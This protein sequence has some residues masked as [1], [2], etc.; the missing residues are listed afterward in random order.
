MSIPPEIFHNTIHKQQ[1]TGQSPR[2]GAALIKD[3]RT[4]F[5]P[6]TDSEHAEKGSVECP[7]NTESIPI[8]VTPPI[9]PSAFFQDGSPL[10]QQQTWRIPVVLPLAD[11]TENTLAWASSLKLLRTLVHH[12]GIYALAACLSPLLSLLLTPFLV[13]S[14]SRTDYGALVVLNAASVFLTALTQAG[15]GPAFAHTVSSH[16]HNSPQAQ[17]TALATMTRLLLLTSCTITVLLWLCA[18]LV[19]AVLLRDPV[20]TSQVRVTAIIVCLQN[21]TVPGMT[22]LRVSGRARTFAL[23][24]TGSVLCNLVVTL[25]LVKFAHLGLMGALYGTASST[26]VLIAGSAPFLRNKH[27]TRFHREIAAK[28]LAF[29]VTT[30]PGLLSVWVL[31]LADR[32]FLLCYGSLTQ[33]ASYS[34]AYTLSSMLAP[35]VIS[36]FALAWYALMHSLARKPRAKELF[37][38]IFRWYST[39]LLFA[40]CAGAVVADALLRG[41]FPPAYAEQEMIIPLIALA[42][43]L[44]G[45]FDLFAVGLH[46]RNKVGY[47]VFYMPC[48]A[49]LNLLC[50]IVLIPRYGTMGAALATLLAYLALAIMA[51]VV[52]QRVYPIPFEIGR[53]TLA[54]ALGVICYTVAFWL[55]HLTAHDI[56]NTLFHWCLIVALLCSYGCVLLALCKFPLRKLRANK[57]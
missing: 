38:L 40:A 17:H 52:N 22:W 56:V 9:T 34:V 8:I 5:S 43:V 4:L 39:C 49:F 46:V 31:Q 37:Q 13:H 28:L 26:L 42:N 16:Q 21:M 12:S 14:L 54:L 55:L 50:D 6:D 29:G 33:T 36:P 11:I 57:Q 30:L 32:Y 23:L 44:Y 47:S 45:L 19:A 27:K 1:A 24:T 35:L 7:I 20:Y 3:P 15:L 41:W 51:Y 10:D 18:P 25:W 48:A 53:F 2:R